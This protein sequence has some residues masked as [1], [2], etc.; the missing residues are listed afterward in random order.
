LATNAGIFAVTLTPAQNNGF[1]GLT[2]TGDD[3][4]TMSAAG[5][6]TGLNTATTTDDVIYA[7]TGTG[8]VF[9]ASTTA[10]DYK[11]TGGT[12]NTFNFGATLT[13]ADTITGSAGADVLNLTGTATGSVA[14]TAIETI[15]V[16]FPAAGATFTTG[17]IAFAGA[18]T[19]NASTSVGPVTLVLT[20]YDPT[21]GTLVVTDGPGNDVITN[22]STDAIN[23]LSTINLS[24]GGADVINFTSVGY[25]AETSF[26]LT[27]GSFTGGSGAGADKIITTI[28]ATA[29]TAAFRTIGAANAVVPT[30]SSVNVIPSTLVT[31]SDFTAVANGGAVEVAMTTA[32]NG[33]IGTAV[34][35]TTA[36]Y[37]SGAN[38]GKVGIYGV[39]TTAAAIATGSFGVELLGVLTLTGGADTLVLANFI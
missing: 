1:T 12:A 2:V 16:T 7:L 38:A 14:V 11:V 15:N 39:T 28:G 13:A 25:V 4:I 33:V 23:L 24:S 26:P 20:S 6:I 29:Q 10:N 17:A 35:F 22:I 27:V 37:G 36:L 5:T 9:T 21:G 32:F 31:V 8:N 30:V 19:I 18:S 34:L 3:T